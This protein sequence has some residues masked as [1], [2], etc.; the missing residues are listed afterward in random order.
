M[1]CVENWK[2]PQNWK[3]FHE[4][5]ERVVSHRAFKVRARHYAAALESMHVG[6]RRLG[7]E[8]SSLCLRWL[9]GL[10]QAGMEVYRTV[11]SM[12]PFQLWGWDKV[13]VAGQM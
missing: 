9:C 4:T 7:S 3:I 6:V 10:G 2:Y 11:E 1:E 8:V 13:E 12:Q 5:E